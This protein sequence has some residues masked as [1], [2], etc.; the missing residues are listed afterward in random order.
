MYD[1]TVSVVIP[2]FN[3][4]QYIGRTL[5]SVV[6]QT[7]R[8]FEILVI[9]DGSSDRGVDIVRDFKDAR[10][11]LIQQQNAGVSAARNRG[12]SE[13]RS[14]LIAFLDADDEWTPEFL[15]TII[16]LQMKYP[17]AG[18]YAAAYN[19]V[20]PDGRIL[21]TESKTAPSES[22]ESIFFNYFKATLQGK[23][24][25]HVSAVC[26]PARIFH[27]LGGFLVG[28]KFG[29]DLEMFCRIAMR[30]PVAFSRNIGALYYLD[31]ANSALNAHITVEDLPF[32]RTV[33]TA[34][35]IGIVDSEM[36][37]DLQ[38]YIAGCQL[39]N[40]KQNVLAGN[41]PTAK[42]MLRNCQPPRSRLRKLWWSFWASMPF[43][44][45]S[46]ASQINRDM[47]G[48]AKYIRSSR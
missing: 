34:I 38:E 6:T 37:E 43:T 12:I 13:A 7:M 24:A 14:D 32:V 9:D 40:V 39:W 20:M 29:E 28:E 46:F 26:I 30:Y 41:R 11:R 27:E 3:K 15:E 4:E 10:I 2:L 18:I 44:V 47:K 42:R 16:K 31:A 1:K 21:P 23:A 22:C 35:E 5:Q 33:R 8:S 17:E 19:T 25:M 45:T 36:T 48:I